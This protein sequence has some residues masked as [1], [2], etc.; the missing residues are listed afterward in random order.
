MARHLWTKL[1]GSVWDMHRK[2]LKKDAF[3]LIEVMIAVV[4]I[5]VVIMS[6][7]Q[8]QG[9][10]MHLFSSFAKKEMLNQYGSFFIANEDY[11][12]EKKSISL[13][14]LVSEFKIEDELRMELKKIKAD[15][16]YQD[17]K[18]EELENAQIGM[19][20][21]ILRSSEASCAFLRLKTR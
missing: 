11:G 7:L 5:S 21:T 17:I 12:Y 10:N 14:E 13:D 16:A 1:S 3:S 19:G 9:N 6:L 15:I 2:R 18:N 4:I 20:R 8:L